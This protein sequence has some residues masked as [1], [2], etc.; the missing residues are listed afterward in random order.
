MAKQYNPKAIEKKWQKSWEKQRALSQASE[1][2][3]KKKYY[4]L[5]MFPYPSGD[6]LHVGHVENYTATDIYAR[7]K[8]M[9]G[10][11]VLHP[12]GWDAFGLPAENFAIKTGVHP[13]KK[14]HQ[15]IKNFTR[16]IKSLGISYD[17]SREIDT[18][19]PE[20]YKWTQWFFLFLYKNGLAYKKKANV[21]WCPS[22]QTVLANEQV[23]DG[24]CERCKTEVV[25]KE[26]EQWFFKITDFIEDQKFQGR[27]VKG[28]LSGLEKV[29]WPESTKD[30]QRNWIGRSEG[31]LVKFEVRSA[32][33]GTSH[34]S[35]TEEGKGEADF[36]EV[37]TTR[38]DTIFG[39]T[40]VVVAP[41]HAL[42][43]ERKAE[44]KNYKAVQKYL[45]KVAKKTEL[46][47]TDLAKDK[48]G[49]KIEGIEA[50]HPFTGEALPL[51]VA[52]YVLGH[53]GTGAV[54]AVPA[55]DERDF[56]FAK[57]YK[58]P[59]KVSV[60]PFF[61]VTEGQDAVRPN[62]PTVRRRTA[63]ALVKH[64]KEDKYLC[65]DWEKFGWHS[66]I[67]GGIEEGEDPIEAA[68]REIIEETGYQR[69]VFKKFVGEAM[70]TSFF[71]AHKDVNR[72]AD[73]VGMLFEL[74]DDVWEEPK[75]EETTNH[76]TVWI[77]GN[78]MEKFLNLKNFQYMWQVLKKG[79]EC[80]SEDG[81]VVNSGEY[82]NLT[83]QEAR[84]KM[85]QWLEKKKLGG[86]QVN[87]R[88][89]DWLVSRQRYWGAPI[90]IVYCEACGRKEAKVK[91]NVN[92][93]HQAVWRKLISGE[94]SVEIR[95]LNPEEPK[96]YFGNVA[97]G[98]L[99]AFVNKK[100][101]EES[102][103]RVKKVYFFRTMKDVFDHPDLVEKVWTKEVAADMTYED[104]EAAYAR[105]APGYL[106]KIRQHGLV[107]WEIEPASIAKVIPV[108]EKDLPVKL[109]KDVDFRPTG[110]SPLVRSVSFQKV[111]CPKCGKQARREADTMD[112]FVCSSWYYLRFAD[113]KNTKKFADSKKLIHW[114]PVDFY[115]GGA[116]HTVLH[117]LYARFFT[118]ALYKYGYAH[119]D[120]PFQ[121]LRHQGMVLA[122]DGR[123]MSKSL[124]N[125]VNPDDVV[126][127][128][129]ADTLRLYEMFMG[130]LEESKSWN[131]SSIVGLRRFLEKVW[132]L[133]D[134]VIDK[135]KNKEQGTKNREIQVLLHKTIKK[136]TEDIEAL[137][138]NTAISALMVLANGL[139]KEA[140]LS[141][142][143]YSQFLILL[144][145]FAP[146]IT[147]ELWQAQGNKKSIFLEAWPKA[148]ARYLKVEEV[149]LIVQVNGRLRARVKVKAGSDQ[150]QAEEAAL[151]D[152][153][154]QAHTSGKQLRK[155]IYVPDKLLNFVVG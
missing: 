72:Y 17:W 21:N 46:E 12:I 26:L 76:K 82:S 130:P 66:G 80:F 60:A 94:K 93:A 51:F 106:E 15:N 125:V 135:A 146:H 44:I 107:A 64:W 78:E 77:A 114:L 90:P 142:N 89:R 102:V 151:S 6:G 35:P 95:A 29:D 75:E 71:A 37:F 139:E 67:I 105:F 88:L 54:M 39:C 32:T 18:S 92:I 58:L 128:F 43:R 73:G 140:S 19:S 57:K 124:G 14:T 41:E 23:V 63:F 10:F 104:A 87:Y 31:A 22:C 127:A 97:E 5:D 147:E 65:L 119:F 84:E 144:S 42:L 143:I 155:V 116:E 129:G 8:R 153:K 16:Q 111:K 50:I 131:T 136:V 40:Y 52:D 154:V 122:E 48:T 103:V 74:E 53:Y 96:R 112:T 149:E 47:R 4:I 121:K 24:V 28:L 30:A 115:M 123:K 83:S 120:E 61:A 132:R 13:D 34:F 25:Q 7:F 27:K 110:E 152:E 86:K 20:Y 9:R 133:Q 33:L 68:K 118:K 141:E 49:V 36:L 69:P 79:E 3:S 137:R 150:K 148:N 138:F 100:T 145:P 98:D 101:K 134:K 81:V 45:D 2:S 55:H 117:L 126:K 1:K 38:L 108:R 99:I 113:P 109:P 11:E 59:T 62:K 91:L 70:H 56:A 85:A